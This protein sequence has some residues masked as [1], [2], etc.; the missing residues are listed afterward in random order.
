MITGMDGFEWIAQMGYGLE[1]DEGG[2]PSVP[3]TAPSSSR[4]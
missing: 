4:V 3:A 2:T 1:E